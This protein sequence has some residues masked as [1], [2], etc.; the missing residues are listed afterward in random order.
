MRTMKAGNRSEDPWEYMHS[1]K[2][3]N[4]TMFILLEKKYDYERI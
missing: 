4:M 2:P 1:S 3:L